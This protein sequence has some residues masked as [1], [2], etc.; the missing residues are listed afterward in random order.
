MEKY[1]LG[2]THGTIYGALIEFADQRTVFSGIRPRGT[3]QHGHAIHKT[4]LV[5]ESGEQYIYLD[6]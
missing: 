3:L 2:V 6:F 5:S 1:I 4:C